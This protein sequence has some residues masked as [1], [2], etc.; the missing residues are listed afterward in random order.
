MLQMSS[1]ECFKALQ[2]MFSTG[3][4]E[5]VSVGQETIDDI[6]SYESQS[7]LDGCSI[8]I[9]WQSND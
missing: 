3:L 4:T 9:L 6:G 5:Y 7:M 8:D 1:R 2:S